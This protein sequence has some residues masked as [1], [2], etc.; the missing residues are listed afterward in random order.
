MLTNSL[1]LSMYCNFIFFNLKMFFKEQD[2]GA[3]YHQ[4]FSMYK[5]NILEEVD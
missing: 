1:I 5:V 2:K 4:Y 3:F